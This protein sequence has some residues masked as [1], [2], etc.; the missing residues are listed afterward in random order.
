MSEAGSEIVQ[1]GAAGRVF[2]VAQREEADRAE[3]VQ[4]SWG[5]LAG[6]ICWAR[7]Q[8]PEQQQLMAKQLTQEAEQQRRERA[9]QYTER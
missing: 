7:G 6:R 1:R 9:M 3:E 5:E 4:P 2:E 8:R